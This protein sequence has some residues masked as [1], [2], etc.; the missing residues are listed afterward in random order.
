MS[1]DHSPTSF[2][3][4]V[5][6]SWD[7]FWFQ[8]VAAAQLH[9][10]RALAGITLLAW[11]LSYAFTYQDYFGANG[12]FDAEA[13]GTASKLPSEANVPI[14]WSHSLIPSSPALLGTLYAG[15][16]LVAALYTLGIAL[17]LVA[18]LAWLVVMIFTSNPV[19]YYGGDALLIILTMYL[20]I[21]YLFLGWDRANLAGSALGAANTALWK[22]RSA[23]APSVVANLTLRLIQVHF[24]IVILM[25]ALHKLQIPE[26]WAGDAI[27]YPLYP[28]FESKISDLLARSGQ[29]DGTLWFISLGTYAT[30]AWQLTYPFQPA[31]SFGRWVMLTGALIGWVWCTWVAGWPLYG[32]TIF[33][34][35]VAAVARYSPMLS[36]E[37]QA[38]AS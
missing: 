3:P 34:A 35:S 4:P 1:V 36:G 17:R 31:T 7:R 10:V 33:V 22:F 12:W 11:L 15:S 29:M 37:D 27:W 26:W 13:Y 8:P 9:L 14:K 38:E 28:P 5:F 19:L 21:G 16:L 18:P 6:R 23:V 32:P 2:F 25:S 30:I 20:A 24:A